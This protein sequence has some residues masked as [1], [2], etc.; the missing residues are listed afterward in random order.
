MS[1]LEELYGEELDVIVKWGML[2][3]L[4]IECDDMIPAQAVSVIHRS[5]SW[6][7]KLW[8]GYIQEGSSG[9]N[10]K[11]RSKWWKTFQTT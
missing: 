11:L 3:V 2:F 9:L 6:A 8:R 10:D 4:K 5:R 7:S 1:K